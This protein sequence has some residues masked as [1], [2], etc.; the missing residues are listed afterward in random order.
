LRGRAVLAASRALRPKTSVQRRGLSANQPKPAAPSAKATTPAGNSGTPAGGSAAPSEGA[1]A[2]AGA[3]SSSAGGSGQAG[4]GK[5][6]GYGWGSVA[7][8]GMV[9]SGLPLALVGYRA[10]TDPEFKAELK[11]QMPGPAYDALDQALG[12]V[13]TQIDSVKEMVPSLE[14]PKFE[15]PKFDMPKFEI[16]KIEL[17]KVD[18]PKFELPSALGGKPSAKPSEDESASTAPSEVSTTPDSSESVNTQAEASHDEPLAAPVSTDS[19]PEADAPAQDV[20]H[21]TPP[22]TPSFEEVEKILNPVGPPPEPVVVPEVPLPEAA[23]EVQQHMQQTLTTLT[24][25]NTWS[26][27]ERRIHEMQE[28]VRKRRGVDAEDGNL[29]DPKPCKDLKSANRRIEELAEMVNE[30]SRAEGIRMV[31]A[32][33]H[34]QKEDDLHFAKVLS[35]HQKQL[36]TALSDKLDKVMSAKDAALEKEIKDLSDQYVRKTKQAVSD[37]QDIDQQHLAQELRQRDLELA[38]LLEQS[39]LEEKRHAS[40]SY[41]EE[42]K[43]R[44]RELESV[45]VRLAAM[46]QLLSDSSSEQRDSFKVHRLSLATLSLVSALD[47]KRNFAQ[48]L[49]FLK[50]AGHGDPVVEAATASIPPHLAEQGV[51]TYQHLVSRLKRVAKEGKRAALVPQDGGIM[52]EALATLVSKIPELRERGLPRGDVSDP[53]IAF[54]RARYFAAGGHLYTAT[55][56]LRQLPPRPQ[57]VADGWVREAEDRLIVDQAIM[58]IRAHIAA[59]VAALA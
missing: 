49:A 7:L 31:Q 55:Q 59:L 2:T 37:T 43:D 54:A 15:V 9:V 13:E 24:D 5:K 41:F 33:R 56:Q 42:C 17:P 12:A 11:N 21:T 36:E 30:F 14:V 22:P 6:S 18:L 35:D 29:V 44:V 58:L 39:I 34:Q 48:E 45:R 10:S 23:E 1:K 8:G 52:A 16:P 32:L 50:E 4:G 20:S 40:D 46:D 19:T 57:A 27:R 28:E 25:A 38:D 51:P 53:D 3:Q 47:T 26:E